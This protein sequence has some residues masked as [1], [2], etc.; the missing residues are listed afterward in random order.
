[1]RLQKF[2]SQQGICSRRTAEDWIRAG[3]I[4]VNGDLSTLGDRYT[5]GDSVTIDGKE[6]EVQE[7]KTLVLAWN[8]PISVEVTFDNKHGGKTLKDF[9]FGPER[10]VPIGRL[11]K[12]SH[13]LILL[14]NDGDLANELMHPR[15]G[16]EKSYIVHVDRDLKPECLERLRNGTI[17]INDRKVSPCRVQQIEERAFKIILK[18]GRNRQIRR[19]CEACGGLSV[20]DLLRIRVNTT[21]LDDLHDGAFRKLS[22]TEVSQLRELR[23]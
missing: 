23:D 1:M 20:T 3:R 12:D 13:G 6:I 8:K 19:M 15:Y 16:H 22:D 21:H 9:D 7:K 5:E 10:V 11:D 18:E 4:R 17:E 2:L 14:T